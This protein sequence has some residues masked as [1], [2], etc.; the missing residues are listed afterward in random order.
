[1]PNGSLRPETVIHWDHAQGPLADQKADIRAD[2]C[3]AEQSL[4]RL[5]RLCDLE[6]EEAGRLRF[7]RLMTR[8]GMSA[9]RLTGDDPKQPDQGQ[10]AIEPTSLKVRFGIERP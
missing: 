9:T 8:S 7:R 5:R 6:A 10:I 1:M 2:C 3:G 4:R